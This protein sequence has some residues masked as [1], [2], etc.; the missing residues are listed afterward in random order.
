M[1][2]TGGGWG[3]YTSFRHCP[4]FSV[5]S[6]DLRTRVEQTTL[7]GDYPKM[8]TGGLVGGAGG[9]RGE[10]GWCVCGVVARMT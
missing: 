3:L 1:S 8:G 9:G 5:V 6:V 10:G 2:E 4:A 7:E